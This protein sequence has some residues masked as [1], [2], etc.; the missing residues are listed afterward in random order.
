MMAPVPSVRAATECKADVRARLT[1][2]EVRDSIA[3]KTFAVEIDTK[4]ACA[5]VYVDFTAT[6]RLFDGEEI[7]VTKR[8]YRKVTGPSTYKAD[9]RIARDSEL[10]DWK[11]SVARCVVCGTE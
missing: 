1:R 10:L 11:F 4:E 5:T 9:H 6:E 3:E 2:E 7:T 8:G